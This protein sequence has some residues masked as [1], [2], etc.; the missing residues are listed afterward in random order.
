MENST[1]V[2]PEALQYT[3]ERED[4]YT[5]PA[6]KPPSPIIYQS[7]L[8]F[9]SLLAARFY[10]ML[11]FPILEGRGTCMQITSVPNSPAV[12]NYTFS[13]KQLEEPSNLGG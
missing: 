7:V 5:I 8:D 3:R 9:I 1:L 2:I 11:I 6:L 13:Y 4:G 12:Q 10:F